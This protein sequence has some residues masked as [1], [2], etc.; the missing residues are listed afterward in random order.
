MDL[1]S[2]LLRLAV[3]SP[4]MAFVCVVLVFALAFIPVAAVVTWWET[5][6]D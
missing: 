1:V 3:T 5:R 6:D 2:Q 4:A